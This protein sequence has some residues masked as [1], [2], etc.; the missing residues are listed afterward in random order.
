MCGDTTLLLPL[1]A[2]LPADII[3][4]DFPVDLAEARRKLNPNHIIS[5]NVSTVTVLLHG[6]PEDVYD[7]SAS[8]FAKVGPKYIAGSGCEIS[9]LSPLENVKAIVDFASTHCNG[10][11]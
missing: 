6:T 1:M 4:L 7:S 5:G 3:E 11:K 2:R 9:P 10:T 8:C